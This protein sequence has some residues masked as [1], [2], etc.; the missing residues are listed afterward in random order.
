MD[1]LGGLIGEEEEEGDGDTQ[2]DSII[3]HS[4]DPNHKTGNP[5]NIESIRKSNGAK[6]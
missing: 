2:V 1:N 6:L 3:E 4:L 5:R